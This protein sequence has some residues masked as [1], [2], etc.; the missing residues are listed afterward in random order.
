ML[1]IIAAAAF[2]LAAVM[3]GATFFGIDAA[4]IM[5]ELQWLHFLA[6]V[7][8]VAM[9][10]S[11]RLYYWR[12][13]DFASN[14][15]FED[16]FADCPRWTVLFQIILVIVVFA[17]GVDAL[18]GG[19]GGQAAISTNGEYV[20]QSKGQTIRAISLQ[21][22]DAQMLREHRLVSAFWMMFLFFS[23]AWFLLR[24]PPPVRTA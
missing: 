12:H 16:I 3:F 23:V 4:R 1:G 10:V 11:A 21:E 5:P 15:P 7:L 13:P 8:S 22:Y 18:V 19:D 6:L 20:L 14:N 2:C 17:C 9:A 24:R